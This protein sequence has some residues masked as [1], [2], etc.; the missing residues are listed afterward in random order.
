MVLKKLPPDAPGAKRLAAR[1]GAA[2]LCVRYREDC[3]AGQ[4]LTTV[5]LIVDQRPLPALAGVR[6]AYGE[7]DLRRK[8]K[9]AG[10]IWDAEQKLWRLPKSSIRK[11]K[12][13][14]RIVTENA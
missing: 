3:R 6:I 10:G 8:V 1:Y 5:E 2:L 11:L 12:L 14:Q 13:E 9:E 7:A 4:R